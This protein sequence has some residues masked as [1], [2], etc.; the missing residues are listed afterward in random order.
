LRKVSEGE[1]WFERTLLSSLL[2]VKEVGLSPRERQLLRLVSQGL[3]NKQVA[4]TLSIAE[5]TVKVYFSKLFR[6]VGVNDR[7][8]LALYGLRNLGAGREAT[9][10]GQGAGATPRSLVV[11]HTPARL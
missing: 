7:F 3:S 2:Q 9:A 11:R 4:A 5:G 8:E 1:M 10:D 6:K